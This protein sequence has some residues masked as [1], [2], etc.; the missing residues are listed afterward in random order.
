VG[1]LYLKEVR[2]NCIS[3]FFSQTVFCLDPKRFAAAHYLSNSK[4][5][6]IRYSVRLKPGKSM[7]HV[8]DITQL[9]AD[10]FF[11]NCGVTTTN[12]DIQCGICYDKI[13]QYRFELCHVKHGVCPACIKRLTECAV[14]RG[15]EMIVFPLEIP[16]DHKC[17]G[18]IE[19]TNYINSAY[20]T[21]F[22]L[23]LP[24]QNRR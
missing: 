4:C 13:R 21:N 3:F 1:L 23:Y 24:R 22:R 7:R 5:A 6:A 2:I 11:P 18:K 15:T 19:K 16:Q 12:E 10:L 9:D 8:K 14:C 20:N 17:K